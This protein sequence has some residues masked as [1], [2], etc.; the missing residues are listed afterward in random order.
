MPN[1]SDDNFLPYSS[2]KTCCIVKPNTP[3]S[4]RIIHFSSNKKALHSIISDGLKSRAQ[5]TEEKQLKPSEFTT[6]NPILTDKDISIY[7][8]APLKKS[9][10]LG[11]A[12]GSEDTLLHFPWVAIDVDPDTT[13]V[14]NSEL[15]LQDKS[16]YMIQKVTLRQWLDYKNKEEEIRNK[17][18]KNLEEN[19]EDGSII[20]TDPF[21]A[22]PRRVFYNSPLIEAPE[23]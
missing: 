1:N 20:L 12:Y 17:L 5:L 4:V 9:N 22:E 14:F 8:K 13:Y 6:K 11:E 23:C 21:T 10:Y 15:R 19:N 3:N 2:D 18:E 16:A 7:F